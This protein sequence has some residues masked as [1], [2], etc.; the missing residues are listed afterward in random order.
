MLIKILSTL[1]ELKKKLKEGGKEFELLS[2][3]RLIET[4]PDNN[5]ARL[6]LAEFF[7]M[8][9]LK[10]FSAKELQIVFKSNPENQTL[11][12]LMD[13]LGIEKTTSS[14]V[15]EIAEAEISDILFED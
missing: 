12:R 13:E 10:S 6:L 5:A 9:N 4:E 8:Q 15:K 14:D 7:W 2:L 1:E 11:Q 3:L